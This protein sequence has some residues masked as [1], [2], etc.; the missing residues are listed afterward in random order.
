MPVRVEL[1]LCYSR[2]ILGEWI[3]QVAS[4]IIFFY[5]LP[6]GQFITCL[7]LYLEGENLI[8]ELK[9]QIISSIGMSFVKRHGCN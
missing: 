6:F 8:N 3:L 2:M 1:K 5:N 4:L 7:H 9:I